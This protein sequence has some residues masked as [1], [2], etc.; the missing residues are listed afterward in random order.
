ME[1][2]DLH[3]V[4]IK[5]IESAILNVF[6]SK[7]CVIYEFYKLLIKINTVMHT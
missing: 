5:T 6:D 1:T 2:A 3:R 7:E 4:N